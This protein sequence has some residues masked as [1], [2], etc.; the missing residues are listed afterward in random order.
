MQQAILVKE[1][2]PA[3]KRRSDRREKRI[4]QYLESFSLPALPDSPFWPA[5]NPIDNR[6][7]MV[8]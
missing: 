7:F 8:V 1:K 2:K 3:M 6:I 4:T 5:N